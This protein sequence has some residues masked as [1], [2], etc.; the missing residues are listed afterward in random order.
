MELPPHKRDKN[1][2][3]SIQ[4]PCIQL[5]MPTKLNTNNPPV[6]L[7]LHGENTWR[8]L[9]K[10]TNFSEISSL[11]LPLNLVATRN[12]LSKPPEVNNGTTSMKLCQNAD[13]EEVP[14]KLSILMST[15]SLPLRMSMEILKTS[16]R[17]M[18]S[19]SKVPSS[20][21]TCEFLE[22]HISYFT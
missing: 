5:E 8:E 19:T 18:P 6:N 11:E 15:F 14:G 16:T 7:R 17:M 21:L 22:T 4:I 12:A 3:K 9:N 10:C 13:A 20:D 1:S 2:L